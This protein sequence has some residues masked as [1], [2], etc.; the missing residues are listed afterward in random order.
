MNF[1]ICAA[2]SKKS[3][4]ID[5][6]NSLRG[7]A[8]LS[9][10]LYH[11][12]VTTIDFVQN[13]TVKDVFHYGSRGVQL[14]FI[15]SGIVIPLSLLNSGYTLKNSWTFIKKRFV[16][17]EPPYLVAV[18]VGILYLIVRNYIP[19]TT[20]IDMTPSFTEIIL[21]LGYL[22]PFV[23]GAE[24]INP[25]FWTLA[26]EFQYYLALALLF[27]LILSKKTTLRLLF[28]AIFIGVSFIPI[29]T[30]FFPYW[31][32]YFMVGITYVLFKK[33]FVGLAEYAILSVVL[34]AVIIYHQ[35]LVDF[36]IALGAICLIHFVPKFKWKPT[37]FLG[38]ISYSLYL[39]HSMIG[40]ALV[41]YLSHIY[42]SPIQQFLV[43]A[44]GV[45]VS[46]LSAYVMYRLI[47]KPTHAF[48][49]K[50]K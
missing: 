21:H 19:G 22:I 46:I 2:V 27:P 25:V 4:H 47:E 10:V 3:D 38:K 31:A 9:V 44:A 24:W 18:A 42:R 39:L 43:I 40:S 17:I 30:H 13:E 45:M 35:N 12:V 20:E 28:Y 34:G 50:I 26:V 7:I 14:F 33:E 16:R 29:G 15:I 23:E 36:G 8:A 41:N 6:I 37:L 49:R 1:Y 5:I 48:A 32:S 11:F